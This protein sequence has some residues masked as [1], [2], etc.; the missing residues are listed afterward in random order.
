VGQVEVIAVCFH[1]WEL[2]LEG[3]KWFLDKG[4]DP[5]LAHRDTGENS[6]HSLTA[7]PHELEKRFEAIK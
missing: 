5:D 4:V 3:L 6:L 1:A 7:K 2:N